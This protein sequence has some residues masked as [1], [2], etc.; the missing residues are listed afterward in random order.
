M[1]SL[2]FLFFFYSFHVFKNFCKIIVKEQR[3]FP[4]H[5]CLSISQSSQRLAA[6]S[7]ALWISVSPIVFSSSYLAPRLS[8]PQPKLASSLTQ[9]FHHFAHLNIV[10][11]ISALYTS[12]QLP[13]THLGS[14]LFLPAPTHTLY[15]CKPEAF[16]H[17]A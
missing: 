9:T 17:S 6:S 1:V 5:L 11:S 4:P 16:K 8:L 13:H 15:Y 14:S 3:I 12:S 10:F 2:L 7:V